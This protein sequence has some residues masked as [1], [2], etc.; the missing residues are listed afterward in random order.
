MHATAIRFALS[1]LFCGLVLTS[2]FLPQR[3]LAEEKK[4]VPSAVRVILVK[5]GKMMNEQ[6]Y[7]Q[8]IA[9]LTEFSAGISAGNDAPHPHPEID[10][11]LG[12][13]YLLR[14]RF[15]EARRALDRAV[16]KDPR[17]RSAWLNLAKVTY[18]LHDYKRAAECFVNAY[19]LDP[20]KNPEH[21][22]FGA[23]AHLLAQDNAG[24]VA[25]FERLL[26]AHADQVHLEWRENLVHA[27]IGAG[28]SLRA[29]PH[30]KRL[31]EE[32]RGDKQVQWQEI[33]LYH[34]LQ[35][36]RDD[37]ALAAAESFCRTLPTETKWWRALAH[38]HLRHNR[39]QPALTALLVA[40]YLEPLSKEES[41]LVADL[42]LQLGVP[43]KA[44][45]LYQDI[46]AD[47]KNPQP[48]TNLVV[49]LQQTG[50]IDQA[51]AVLDTFATDTLGPELAML[52][53][54]LQN[55]QSLG[56]NGRSERSTTF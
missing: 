44:A 15:E 11:T 12:T 48:L 47:T 31:A 32:S 34:Y 52:K 33:L 22:Y 46:L 54:G 9:L 13:C 56:R 28:E 8:A 35:L 14:D 43:V 37:E 39:Y 30:I 24:A 25:V 21:L 16:E 41:R 2:S 19:D 23:V 45:E 18:E 50:Q 6:R 3:S 40:G 53:V 51:L 17:H 26:V 4:D 20:D 5:A 42:Y 1:L 27:L 55:D 10:F 29:L 38:I 36:D 49:A 7:D